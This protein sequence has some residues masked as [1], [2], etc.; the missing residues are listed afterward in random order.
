MQSNKKLNNLFHLAAQKYCFEP[1]CGPPYWLPM[2]FKALCVE[3][4]F[5]ADIQGLLLQEK[6][7]LVWIWL[8]LEEL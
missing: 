3:L 4:F 2:L 1:L 8:L 5:S 7:D 6:R